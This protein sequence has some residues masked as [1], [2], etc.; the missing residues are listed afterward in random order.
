MVRRLLLVALLASA[1][2][3]VAQAP[4]WTATLDTPPSS[5]LGVATHA[6]PDVAGGFYV[7]GA[8][9][10]APRGLDVSL[11]RIGSDGVRIWSMTLPGE[12]ARDEIPL[13][14]SATAS[15]PCAAYAR[16]DG[17]DRVAAIV[18]TDPDGDVRWQTTLD[19]LALGL[20]AF[21]LRGT[22]AFG[23]YADGGAVVV[24]SAT[25]GDS[26]VLVIRLDPEGN[27]AWRVVHELSTSFY[28]P[29]IAAE[30]L[31]DSGVVV[32]IEAGG[33]VRVG[34]DGDVV[35]TVAP[36]NEFGGSNGLLD[37]A[38]GPDGDIAAVGHDT[39][40]G[41]MPPPLVAR[42][43]P[44]G[45]PRWEATYD[46][47]PTEIVAFA[48]TGETLHAHGFEVTAVDASGAPRWSAFLGSGQL[49]AVLPDAWGG[50]VLVG[51]TAPG[52]DEER[53]TV[54]VT[55]LDAAGDIRWSGERTGDGPT[56]ALGAALLNDDR[57]G[58]AGARA[59]GSGTVPD[60]VVFDQG[61][62]ASVTTTDAAP[63]PFSSAAALAAVADGA[64]L[65]GDRVGADGVIRRHVTKLDAA[66]AQ[67]W[68]TG[69]PGL[70]N[71]L[72]FAIAPDGSSIVAGRTGSYLDWDIGIAR[73]DATGEILWEATYVG[74]SGD[75][76]PRTLV[77]MPDGGAVVTVVQGRLSDREVVAIGYGPT[78]EVQWLDVLSTATS[79]YGRT[80]TASRLGDGVVVA[81]DV[82]GTAVVR[83][84]GPDGGVRWEHQSQGTPSAIV[85]AP[86]GGV[87]FTGA[88]TR[89]LD[90]S[91]AQVW[92]S[93]LR[94]SSIV[95]GAGG[96]VT[97]ATDPPGDGARR[98]APIQ[99]TRFSA[100]GAQIWA[101]TF[102]PDLGHGLG[103]A[104][105]TGL[106]DAGEEAVYVSLSSVANGYVDGGVLLVARFGTE[107]WRYAL[108]A[109]ETE[110]RISTRPRI[111]LGDGGALYVADTQGG[112][113]TYGTHPSRLYRAAT[114]S[115]A[116]VSRFDGATLPVDAEAP[117]ASGAR[118]ALASAS[119][120]PFRQTATVTLS[121]ADGVGPVRVEVI[122]ALGRLVAT[123]H[124]GPLGAGAHRL[125]VNGARL[126]VGTYLVRASGRGETT[127]VPI[128]VVR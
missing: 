90:A 118:L 3:A 48:S 107:R 43:A 87:C 5:P 75:D 69:L 25:S 77:P 33:L 102:H 13:A 100:G 11:G 109:A 6:A 41:K 36:Q 27:E 111:A 76:G 88:A 97:V 4:A 49:A 82:G 17:L 10:G 92:E 14:L 103:Y 38:V 37:I 9:S 108:P 67:V 125:E 71:D 113:V 112:T 1:G 12:E 114:Y 101:S 105:H 32:A 50:V 96:E 15:G 122:D 29:H 98:P 79:T 31:A 22:F 120:N 99:L 16:A 56:F 21:G 64:L 115:L 7:L 52:R 62:V 42:Y 91:G 66:G 8:A 44:D 18:C 24:S 30:T 74:P 20:D 106:V 59:E 94:G 72:R 34:P 2:G 47:P 110:G 80:I 39:G 58:V 60:A 26:R 83:W 35:W 61:V 63:R 73:L 127:A 95:V 46:A 68:A 104:V 45:T 85:A 81:A 78:G 124:E 28:S 117:A 93:G 84:Y 116:R 55:A 40:L 19:G 23:A 54:L 126:P 57:V 123:L 65:L 128:T 53:R 51:S 86:G 89:C 119:P 70:V 121:L